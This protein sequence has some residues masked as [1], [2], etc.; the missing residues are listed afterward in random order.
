MRLVDGFPALHLYHQDGNRQR[1]PRAP[2][3]FLKAFLR[4]LTGAKLSRRR[5]GETRD[6]STWESW[7]RVGAAETWVTWRAWGDVHDSSEY[8]EYYEADLPAISLRWH[9]SYLKSGYHRIPQD[10][11]L[12][13]RF[14]DPA[15]ERTFRRLWKEF[16]QE[17]ARF[18]RD[19]PAV[20]SLDVS[21]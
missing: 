7:G 1:K 19:D 16:F 11:G 4:H 18:T 2:T 9:I 13:V 3:D 14:G 12:R 17:P 8:I 15:T 5:L 10:R 21:P 6:A 20:T